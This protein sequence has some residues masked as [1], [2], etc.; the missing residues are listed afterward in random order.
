MDSW[1]PGPELGP[2]RP[3]RPDPYVV[4]LKRGFTQKIGLCL[5]SSSEILGPEGA[6]VLHFQMR[7]FLVLGVF[8]AHVGKV[9]NCGIFTFF[10]N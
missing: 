3:H 5:T 9:L 2:A 6:I 4:R 7:I 10:G 8:F 1:T